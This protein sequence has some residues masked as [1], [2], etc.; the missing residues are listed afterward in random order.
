MDKIWLEHN[1]DLQMSPYKVVGTHCE[2][3]Y[4]EFV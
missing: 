3:G 2:Q 1:L 4:L